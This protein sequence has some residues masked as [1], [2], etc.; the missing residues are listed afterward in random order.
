MRR[1]RIT[2][3]PQENTTQQSHSALVSERLSSKEEGQ[4][5]LSQRLDQEITTPT[6]QSTQLDTRRQPPKSARLLRD[7]NHSLLQ[8]KVEQALEHTTM[9]RDGIQTSSHTP[10]DKDALQSP[11]TELQLQV[12]TTLNKL[13]ESLDQRLRSSRSISHQLEPVLRLMENQMSD[14]EPMMTERGGTPTSNR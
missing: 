13:K 10:L 11:K 5:R 9:E 7:P 6:G 3:Q 12:N 14:Q 8:V 1:K 2:S 4:R